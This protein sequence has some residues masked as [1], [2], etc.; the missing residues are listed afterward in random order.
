MSDPY[1]NLISAMWLGW[2]AYWWVSSRN[3]KPVLRHESLSSRFSHIAP[4]VLAVLFFAAPGLSFPI[5]RERFLPVATWTFPVAAILTAIGLAFAVWAR[6]CLGTNWSGTVTIKQDHELVTS[7]P[8]A[9]ARHPIYAGLLLA[10][11]GSAIAIGEWRS[12]LAVVLAALAFWRK[13]RI[14]ER[15][16]RDRFGE[17][18]PAYCE[19]VRALIPFVL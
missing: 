15:W 10:F 3:V 5:L 12:V 8:Y 19:R 18:Y 14:E 6:R 13:L 7:G 9:W 17:T 1:R 4:L 11:V 2:A 16:M